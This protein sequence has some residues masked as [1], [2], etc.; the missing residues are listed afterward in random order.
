MKPLMLEASRLSESIRFEN[1][2]TLI[3]DGVAIIPIVGFLTKR[4]GPWG[5]FEGTSYE[6]IEACLQ[7]ALA[8][9][10]VQNIVLDIDSPG[11]EVSGLFDLCDFIYEARKQK[12]IEAIANDDA[13]S[14]AY[15][16][17]SS[18]GKVWC[19][20]TSGLG[21]IGVIAT[22]CDQSGYD[23]KEG[24]KVTSLFVGK[25]KNDLSPH[26]P[27][28]E[29]AK[30]QT[31]TELSRLYD[32]FVETVAR[33][34][35]LTVDAVRATEAGL[36]F[37]HQAVQQGLADGFMPL[38]ELLSQ[39]LLSDSQNPLL[40]PSTR[41]LAMTQ[42]T[43]H[44]EQQ[45][46][47]EAAPVPASEPGTLQPQAH[48][49]GLIKLCRVAKRPELLASWLENHLSVEEAQE[50]LLKE[51]EA[52]PAMVTAHAEA[53]RAENPLMQAIKKRFK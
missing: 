16:L 10:A 1:D 8:D 46:P 18:A 52:Q 32:L 27:L 48:L 29:Q 30:G 26:E 28:S 2:G 36:F 47:E 13:F 9:S 38:S 7:D 31:I 35:N 17:A 6:E 50:S 24:F 25:H 40:Q 45:M 34:R 37:G 41:R 42:E 20:R 43:E 44:K 19:T 14:A 4:P 49:D 39:P 53:P 5:P 15:A 33:N 3:Q 11:G 22:H 23:Q 21:S 12:P 51:M